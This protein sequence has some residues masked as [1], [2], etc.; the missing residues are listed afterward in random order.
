M[1][2]FSNKKTITQ[3]NN[4][5]FISMGYV[6]VDINRLV[7]RQQNKSSKVN[8]EAIEQSRIIWEQMAQEQFNKA[9]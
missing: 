2:D 4:K 5:T 9:L 6:V 1:K 3:S 8:L 7:P